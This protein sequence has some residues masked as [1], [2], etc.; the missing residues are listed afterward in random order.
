MLHE[1]RPDV[2]KTEPMLTTK[3]VFQLLNVHP[4]TLRRWSDSGII[5]AYRIGTRA[6]RRFK[7]DDVKYFVAR[8]NE[9]E[10]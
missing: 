9:N 2:R 4:N 3:E 8:F 6:D 7:E 5:K 10:V 1:G